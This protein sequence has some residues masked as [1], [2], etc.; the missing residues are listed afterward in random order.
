[1]IRL[2]PRS[3]RTD[4]LFPY[5]TL[6]RSPYSCRFRAPP[7]CQHIGVAHGQTH[8][9]P[10]NASGIVGNCT[11][12]RPVA[13]AQLEDALFE[14]DVRVVD[15]PAS[16]PAA[17]LDEPQDQVLCRTGLEA[18]DAAVIKVAPAHTALADVLARKQLLVNH[19][20]AA[21]TSQAQ[22]QREYLTP[23]VVP[24]QAIDRSLGHAF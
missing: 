4:T 1:M 21:F 14:Q 2:P 5:T 6:F 12:Q 24:E 17:V 11:Q 8:K 19:R 23:D 16:H 15:Q 18:L 13:P 9:L 20:A 3:T 10:D 7:P 22:T